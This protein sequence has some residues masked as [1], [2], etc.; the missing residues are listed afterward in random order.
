MGADAEPLSVSL[1]DLIS[2]ARNRI[3]LV[4]M[5]KGLLDISIYFT[6]GRFV[7]ARS[8]DPGMASGR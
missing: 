4:N 8:E 7:I 6:E 5:V 2:K 3:S 1:M